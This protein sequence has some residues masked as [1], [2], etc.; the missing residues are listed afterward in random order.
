MAN[1]RRPVQ[2]CKTICTNVAVLAS[3]KLSK[4][5]LRTKTMRQACFACKKDILKI[6]QC[7]LQKLFNND[8]F[9]S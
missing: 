3:I 1:C 6:E 7:C 5:D 2:M 4:L 9:W 8:F